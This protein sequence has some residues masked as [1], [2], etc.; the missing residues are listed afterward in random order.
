LQQT[1][2]NFIQKHS[3][4]TDQHTRYIDL[5]SEVGELG[6]ELLKATNY[7]KNPY[8][9]T[10]DTE[11]EIGDCL[12]SLLALCNAMDIDAEDALAA[13]IAKYEKRFAAKG[14]IGSEQFPTA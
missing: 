8:K 6:K 10:D 3:L 9:Q 13:A 11:S 14:N 2:N 7:G 12:F 1:V 5:V 4:Q